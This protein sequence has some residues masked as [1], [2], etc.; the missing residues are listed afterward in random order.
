MKYTLGYTMGNTKAIQKMK[1][2]ILRNTLWK[3]LLEILTGCSHCDNYN[4]TCNGNPMETTTG[5]T[6]DN[7]MKQIA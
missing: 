1:L 6:V 4:G 3:T 7:P 2:E 5:T